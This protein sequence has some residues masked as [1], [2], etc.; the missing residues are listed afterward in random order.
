[1]S[2]HVTI[3]NQRGRRERREYTVLPAPKSMPGI[4][5]LER[6]GKR[7]HG[8]A[9]HT[10]MARKG[11]VGYFLSKPAAQGEDAGPKSSASTGAREPETLGARCNC[12]QKTPSRIRK[13]HAPRPRPCCDAWQCPSSRRTIPSKT[14]SAA[15]ATA[16]ASSTNTLN[17]FSYSFAVN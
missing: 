16:P 15:N 14:Q 11:R 5:R 1:M 8:A 9:Y 3:E 17:A 6:L 13:Q 4:C 10:V 7:R 2:R 12:F